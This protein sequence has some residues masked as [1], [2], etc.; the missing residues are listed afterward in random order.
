VWSLQIEIKGMNKPRIVSMLG[1]Q[2][3][4]LRQL[5]RTFEVTEMSVRSM[6]ISKKLFL[7]YGA[8]AGLT[9]VMSLASVVTVRGLGNAT[10]DLGVRNAGKTFDAGIING[11]TTDLISLARGILI[12]TMTGEPMKVNT[13]LASYSK[14]RADLRKQFADMRAIGVAAGGEALMKELESELDASD[15][16]FQRLSSEA[17]AGQSKEAL[18]TFDTSLL[19]VLNKIAD[20][21][22]SLLVHQKAV[23]AQVDAAAQSDVRHGYWLMAILMALGCAVGASLVWV[24][25]GLNAELTRNASELTEGS[26]QVSSAATQVSVSSQSLA[27]DTSDQAAMIEETSAS[28]EEINSMARRNTESAKSATD[29]VME[30]VK[31]T[32]QT[33]LAVADC[34]DAMNAIG[35][36]SSKIAKTLQVID[37]IA[38][39]TNILALNAAVEAARAG[40]AGMGFAVVAEE[41]G[42]LAQ[43]CSSASEEISVLIEQSLGNS[44][45]GRA[46]MTTLV[47]SGERV[48]QVFASMKVLVEQ[49]SLSSEEQGRGIDQIGRAIQ[50]M[51]Q[52]TQKSA[53]NAEESAAAAEQL[54]AQSEQLRE[55]ADSLGAMIGISTKG[56]SRRPTSRARQSGKGP[57]A[58]ALS[59]P[60]SSSLPLTSRRSS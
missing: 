20:G 27:R 25:R 58:S 60:S 4:P 26:D 44:D 14:T 57:K 30:A 2:W 54:N 8:M 15:E 21:G 43:R 48:N 5:P 33:N 19:P 6:T 34:V 45:T 11:C 37:K 49:I 55:V 7:T 47:E 24:I 56:A 35:E 40:E 10:Q 12:R 46:K 22:T 51:E 53:A 32:E 29:L 13:Y 52:G 1:I 42:N 18:E 28:A 41:V 17:R 38:F 23:M 36:S 16:P 31:S 9:L 39:Q 3:R 59:G 50:K